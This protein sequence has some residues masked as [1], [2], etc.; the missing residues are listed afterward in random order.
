MR[1][2]RDRWLQAVKSD[3]VPS[4]FV[5]L[6]TVRTVEPVDGG[7]SAYRV[8]VKSGLATRLVYRDGQLRGRLDTRF[9]DR[10][11]WWSFLGRVLRPRESTWIIA[12]DMYEQAAG[13]GLFQLIADRQIILKDG[14]GSDA[15]ECE[16]DK[17][18]RGCCITADPPTIIV[19][20]RAG[21]GGTMR[22]LDVRNYG[23]PDS[24]SRDS[25]ETN[26]QHLVD[27]L[28][29]WLKML[30]DHRLGSLQSTAASQSLIGWRR[31]YMDDCVYVHD[32]QTALRLERHAI[33]G[34][35]CECRF[36][37]TVSQR[38]GLFGDSG[39]I[40]AGNR[41]IEID[42][43][44]YH[45]D[46]NSAYPYAAA[47]TRMPTVL[48]GYYDSPSISLVN[49]AKWD[50]ISIADCV[51]KAEFPRYPYRAASGKLILYPVG[52]YRTVLADPEFSRAWQAGEV[53]HVNALATYERG[54]PFRRYMTDLYTLRQ[55]HRSVG[56]TVM[57]G[58]IK[59]LMVGF[60]GKLGQ[61]PKSWIRD[62][63]RKSPI[64]FGAWFGTNP[65][66]GRLCRW[67]AIGWECEYLDE[68]EEGGST[69]PAITAVIQSAVRCELEDAIQ[70]A[71]P[72]RVW[73]CDTD[74]IWT[75]GIG[76]SRMRAASK[77]DDD[78]FGKWKVSGTYRSVDFRG[79]K[80]H[81]ADGRT[82]RAGVPIS[83]TRPDEA[84][85]RRAK[86]PDIDYACLGNHEP[87]PIVIDLE[88][89]GSSTYRHGRVGYE[90]YVTPF[91]VTEDYD[92]GR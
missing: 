58:C 1:P 30:K 77:C 76:Y 41:R 14:V 36:I 21:G 27:W 48:S 26:V 90:G 9:P 47:N 56:D 92:H 46:V 55:L 59:S 34:G 80:Y 3:S 54:E 4:S 75:D 45:L 32:H 52:T 15:D 7:V 25:L 42:G 19:C 65:I 73:Y 28:E 81:V 78:A 67:R 10:E 84:I 79:V 11:S 57:A 8:Q 50:R 39:P 60:H 43:P 91:R 62:R 44:V 74:S 24:D 70:I 35:R 31:S 13:L 37:G 89:R 22:W 69:C 68:G 12:Y 87:L 63:S 82:V 40:L 23:A 49:E 85:G 51:V 17:G 88:P 72:E 16:S 6:D 64:G 83:E 33:V 5:L 86:M 38:P 53:I 66:S 61:R 18:W 71:G 29:S 2:K 20:R